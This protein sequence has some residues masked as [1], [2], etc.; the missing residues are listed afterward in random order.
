[1]TKTEKVL[2]DINNICGVISECSENLIDN[3]CSDENLKKLQ[4][5]LKT[6]EVIADTL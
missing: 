3:E 2:S 1:M 6:L 5:L 4:E